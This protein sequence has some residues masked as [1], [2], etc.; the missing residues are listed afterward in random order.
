MLVTAPVGSHPRA[1][2]VRAALVAGLLLMLFAAAAPPARATFRIINHNDPAGDPTLITYREEDPRGPT[3][4]QLHDADFKSFGPFEGVATAQVVLPA[5]WQVVDIQCIGPDPS[6][7]T[8]DRQAGTVTVMHHAA[9]EQ[10]CSFT[11]RRIPASPAAGAAPA[12]GI[13]PSPPAALLPKV[14]LPRSAAVVGV[15]S[16]RGVATATVR[17]A[18]PS[19]ISGRLLSAGHV[20]GAARIV[21]NAAGD[22]DLSVRIAPRTARRLRALGRRRLTLTLRIVVRPLAAGATQVFTPRVILRL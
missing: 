9:D 17:I 5:G 15:T 19:V 20:V 18:R 21:R 3:V 1:V 2:S 12:T 7:V 11:N 16:K 10:F 4:F 22:Y 6:Q 8:I 14:Q 13:A